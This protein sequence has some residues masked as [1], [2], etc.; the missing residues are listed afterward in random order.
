M[1]FLLP[2]IYYPQD[3]NRRGCIPLEIIRDIAVA[4]NPK[5]NFFAF[6][7]ITQTS[8][9]SFYGTD[10]EDVTEWVSLLVPLFLAAKARFSVLEKESE[11]D[12]SQ[13]KN[14]FIF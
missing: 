1:F 2:I 12:G 3:K 4:A 13:M 10:E 14:L 5:S 6:Q 8:S 11:E 7:I 9:F